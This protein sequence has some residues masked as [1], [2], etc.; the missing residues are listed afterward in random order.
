MKEN[1]TVLS[2]VRFIVV[3]CS[4]TRCTS[5]YTV[6]QLRADHL[7]RGFREVGYHFYVRRNGAL[8]HP[9]PLSEVGAHAYGFNRSSIGICYEGGLDADD[10]PC[11]TRT[12]AQRET[13]RDTLGILKQLYPNAKI[14]GHYQLSANIKKACPCFDARRE[15]QD[16]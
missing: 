7:A 13:L 11:D 12:P 15:Y 1:E 10:H 5:D 3:H 14:V 4:A 16:L 8:L 6:E 2:E 9:R